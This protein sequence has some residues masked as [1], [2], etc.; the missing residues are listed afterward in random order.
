MTKHRSWSDLTRTQ[1]A[2]L[3]L[4]T[5]VQ[6]GLLISAQV[7]L[8]RRSAD[9]VNGPKPLWRALTFINFVGPLSY[10]AVGRRN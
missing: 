10:F 6:I 4:L 9:Q 7:D 2:G 3:G 8:S 1:R 5:A